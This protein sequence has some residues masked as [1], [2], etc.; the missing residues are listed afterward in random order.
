MDALNSSGQVTL[1]ADGQQYAAWYQLRRGVFTV[2]SG[3]T[4]RVVR[5]G[6]AVAA[7]EALARTILRAMV[8]ENGQPAD[9]VIRRN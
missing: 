1:N 2:T 8:R 9:P 4:S 5:V 3:S 7:P 6:A